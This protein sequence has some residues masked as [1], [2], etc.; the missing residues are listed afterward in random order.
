MS[1]RLKLLAI[2]AVLLFVHVCPASPQAAAPGKSAA[3]KE[4][5]LP[6]VDQLVEK[7]AKASGGKEAWAKLQTLVMTGTMEVPAAGLKGTFEVFA[8]APNKIFHIFSLADG[9]FVQKQ[10]FDGQVGWKFDS[11]H[12]L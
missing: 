7:C 4:D 9:R 10:G 12:G 5:A 6:S 11:Q 8:K 3:S 2:V 1:E